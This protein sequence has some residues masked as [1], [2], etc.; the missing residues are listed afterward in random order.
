MHAQ[1]RVGEWRGNVA[2]W[3]DENGDAVRQQGHLEATETDVNLT[4]GKSVVVNT[5]LNV[6]ADFVA[7]T[8]T[9][10]GIRNLATDPG[11]GVVIQSVGKL[12]MTTDGQPISFRGPA[13]D[14]LNGGGFCQALAG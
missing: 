13:D 8:Q 2:T 14:F 6:H 9:V 1:T 4:T 11:H 5:R 3:F 10:T 12:L 7:G